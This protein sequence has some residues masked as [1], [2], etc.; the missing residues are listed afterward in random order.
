M[1]MGIFISM[2]SVESSLDYHLDRQGVLASN[3]TNADTPNYRPKELVFKDS[4]NNASRLIST[5]ENHMQGTSNG[6]YEVLTSKEPQNLDGNAVRLEKAMA[7]LA[8]NTIRYEQGIE[9]TRKQLGL[10]K[11]AAT[12]GGR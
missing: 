7:Q 1:G 4:M 11:Y 2:K 12:A 10:L 9:L 8:G 3:V 5:V 6:S